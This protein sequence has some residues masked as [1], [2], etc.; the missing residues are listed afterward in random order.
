MAPFYPRALGSLFVASD[1]SQS[2][3]GGILTGL[4][5]GARFLGSNLTEKQ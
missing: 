4:Y 3:V 1:D 2:Y 5:T